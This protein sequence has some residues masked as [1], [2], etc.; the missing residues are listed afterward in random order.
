MHRQRLHVTTRVLP[1]SKPAQTPLSEVDGLLAQQGVLEEEQ[2]EQIVREFELLQGQSA[3]TWRAVFCV[4]AAFLAAAFFIMACEQHSL[5]WGQPVTGKLRASKFSSSSMEVALAAQ[6]IA[7]AGAVVGL[8]SG[9]PPRG[10]APERGCLPASIMQYMWLCL[11]LAISCGCCVYWLA[12]HWKMVALFGVSL[13]A[14]Y[15]LLW[16]PLAPPAYILLCIWVIFS[17]SSTGKDVQDLKKLRY[18]HHTA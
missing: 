2:Q 11:A 17:L 13:G 16:V 9:I 14:R 15:S 1:E 5:P 12:V 18:A 4:G 10:A 7:M 8:Y 3:R 6:A